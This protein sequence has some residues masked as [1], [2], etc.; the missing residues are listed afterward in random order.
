MGGYSPPALIKTKKRR[1]ETRQDGLL[2]DED[3]SR[4]ELQAVAVETSAV[5]NPV[6]CI[7][8][9]SSFL[10]TVSDPKH[11]PVYLRDSV[12]NTNANFDYGA[13]LDFQR[14]MVKKAALKVSTPS[15][16]T[17][18]FTQEG[19]YAFGDAATAEKLM[20][21]TVMGAGESCADPDRYVQSIS[22]SALSAF[23]VP[24]RQDLIIG[25]DYPLLVGLACILVLATATVM[26]LIAYCLHK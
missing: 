6:Y 2:S 21:I 24:Q 16:F 23:G 13:F 17:F 12:L 4:R 22:G 8:V 19:T 10:F 15:L 18:S 7:T 9:G 14:S 11:Y 1:L 25:P 20:V 3:A 26:V 5:Q